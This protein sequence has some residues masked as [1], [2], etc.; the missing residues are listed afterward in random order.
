LFVRSFQETLSS[1]MGIRIPHLLYVDLTTVHG[2]AGLHEGALEDAGILSNELAA[3]P[4]VRAV[5][6]SSSLPFKR[7]TIVP[8]DIPELA[9]LRRRRLDGLFVTAATPDYFKAVGS[10]LLLGRTF[11]AE[12]GAGAPLVT[13]VDALMARKLWPGKNPIGR[14][15]GVGPPPYRY[16]RIIGVIANPPSLSVRDRARMQYFVAA[17]QR[18]DLLSSRYLFVR[19]SG[20]ERA[21]LQLL[22]SFLARHGGGHPTIGSL[23]GL[24]DRGI[25]PLRVASTVLGVVSIIAL[26]LAA[27]GLHAITLYHV[28]RRTREFGIRMAVGCP[29]WG[30]VWLIL[31]DLLI[32][33]AIGVLAGAG[34]ALA[35]ARFITPLL[36]KV[37]A[38]DPGIYLVSAVCLLTA[39]I[40]AAWRPSWLAAHTNLRETIVVEQ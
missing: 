8:V 28:Q 2:Q 3:L 32:T 16:Y 9:R 39:A 31:R 23:R 7:F 35:F 30:I 13:V 29:Q 6:L 34:I 20:G 21:G 26:L 33:A 22:Q 38:F 19:Y 17:A 10:T 27:V 11:T 15:I 12:D 24:A 40:A 36:F 5:G 18:P 25:R 4:G 14:R 37:S 1:R